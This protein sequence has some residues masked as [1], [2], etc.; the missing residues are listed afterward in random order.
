MH[1]SGIYF[2]GRLRDLQQ[3]LVAA[4]SG[5]WN[6]RGTSDQITGK[7]AAHLPLSGRSPHRRATHHRVGATHPGSARVALG[8]LSL[9][10]G[11]HVR[12]NRGRLRLLELPPG[13]VVDGSG[14]DRLA[15]RGVPGFL[16]RGGRVAARAGDPAGLDALGSDVE[17]LV[18][19]LEALRQ[20]LD[21]V[22]RPS[23][24]TA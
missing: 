10:P 11:A 18:Q 6:T 14:A 8:L 1:G 19:D 22:D 24:G 4:R 20:G 5:S 3:F 15:A 7:L 23:T 12:L 9:A 16:A 21:E 2:D 13:D 17:L